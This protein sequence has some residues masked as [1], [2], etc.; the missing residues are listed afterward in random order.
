MIDVEID[1]RLAILYN[2]TQKSLLHFIDRVLLPK[3]TILKK[4]DFYQKKSTEENIH[5]EEVRRFAEKLLEMYGLLSVYPASKY[6]PDRIGPAMD[7]KWQFIVSE[8]YLSMAVNGKQ[9]NHQMSKETTVTNY[10][11]FCDFCA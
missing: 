1:N 9:K 11:L 4:K 3:M 10:T 2:L 7:G 8:E 6:T 5:L